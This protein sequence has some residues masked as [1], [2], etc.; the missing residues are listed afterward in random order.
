NA[1]ALRQR[2]PSGV[3]AWVRP[4][5]IQW[6]E[7]PRPGRL[8]GVERGGEPS[9]ARIGGWQVIASAGHSLAEPLRKA[10]A[11]TDGEGVVLCLPGGLT[12]VPVSLLLQ[13]ARTALAMKPEARFVLVQNGRGAASL[14]RTLHLERPDITTC[15]VD[16]PF[17]HPQAAE[18]VREEALSAQ[19]F[20]EARY[21]ASGVRRE[22][23]LAV[24]PLAEPAGELP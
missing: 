3:D 7:R 19:G 17:D 4:F 13:S 10:F 12:E 23:C 24:L 11:R 21:D 22:P 20:V 18:W 2:I 8:A 5:T 9:P 6:I 1:G 15:V 14:A 16:T